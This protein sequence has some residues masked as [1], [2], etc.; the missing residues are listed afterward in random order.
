MAGPSRTRKTNTLS[1]KGKIDLI[2]TEEKEHLS[3]KDLCIKFNCGKT[4]VYQ[5]LKDK[6]KLKEEW[7]RGERLGDSKRKI[8]KTG[9]EAVNSVVYEW[10]LN[11]RSRNIPIS[12][13]IL[14]EKAK[15]IAQ[16]LNIDSFKASNGWLES[17]RTR[18]EITF[19]QICGEAK[20]VD[21]TVV[22]NWKVKL[23]EIIKNYEPKNIAN[24]D[25]TGL[26]YRALPSKTLTLKKDKCVGGKQPKERLTI[27]MCAFADGS[28]EKP[29]VIGKSLK[30]RCFKNLDVH[31][32]PVI[33]RANKKAWMT[34]ILMDEWL[35]SLNNKMKNQNRHILLFL[36][37]AACHPHLDLSN[38]KLCFLPP[39]TT[40]LS[41]PLDQGIIQ[42]LKVHYRKHVLQSICANMGACKSATELSS[43]I[44]VLDAVR[45]IS[46]AHKNV[47]NN[48]VK[49][50]FRKAG[51]IFTDNEEEIVEPNLEQELTEIQALMEGMNENDVTPQDYI[52][53]DKDL[54]IVN[55]V[56][57]EELLESALDSTSEQIELGDDDQD[58]EEASG[59]GKNINVTC[60]YYI[61]I[62]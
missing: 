47:S 60:Q 54:V 7:L 37:N 49:N 21:L 9:N 40:S 58:E 18:H 53:V 38:I 35:N 41:Q 12:G 10:F 19:K 59:L 14:Q 4:Q 29:L 2:N 48:C 23:A 1:L 51:F 39:N 28:L 44:S 57:V 30:P 43:K 42:N 25:E 16:R 24:C 6:E 20:D 22:E 61:M 13:P 62:I 26:F 36:D 34:S 31:N 3:A 33:W 55:D 56:T 32:L 46:D 52:D 11:A 50:C 15:M 8:R 5:I 45:W 27:L 17:F